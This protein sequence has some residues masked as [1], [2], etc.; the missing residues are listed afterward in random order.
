MKW[1]GF[2]GKWSCPNSNTIPGISSEGPWNT[3]KTLS[4]HS[5]YPCWDSNRVS[6]KYNSRVTAMPNGSV[7]PP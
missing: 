1:N 4:Q 6:P 5:R 3:T 7:T 2:G